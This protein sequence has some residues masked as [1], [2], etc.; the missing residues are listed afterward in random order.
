M[1]QESYFRSTFR[2][3]FGV[4]LTPQVCF[5]PSSRRAQEHAS[6]DCRLMEREGGW[7]V[8]V[9]ILRS[10]VLVVTLLLSAL[11]APWLGLLSVPFPGWLRCAGI[12]VGLSGLVIYVWS[13]LTIGKEWSTDLRLRERHLLGTTGPYSFVRHPIYLA[14][15]F[16]MTSIALVAANRLLI[17]ILM[18][19]IT[20]PVLRIPKEEQMTMEEFGE[21][22]EA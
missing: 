6:A 11:N 2:L 3:I 22:Y 8:F 14:L 5:S 9:R 4:M 7:L 19:S 18:I 12:I 21:E 10:I 20:D 13:R 1:V 17:V 15:I 16:F